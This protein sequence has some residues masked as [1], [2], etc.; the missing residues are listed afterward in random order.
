MYSF[1][2]RHSH[3]HRPYNAHPPE[4][5]PSYFGHSVHSNPDLIVSR[6][7]RLTPCALYPQIVQCDTDYGFFANSPPQLSVV[8][9]PL[10]AHHP[11]TSW[12][13]AYPV[14]PSRQTWRQ[15]HT[16]HLP[17]WRACLGVLPPSRYKSR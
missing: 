5:P 16:S 1:H 10:P 2:P 6:T 4:T 3:N 17:S 12:L 15:S 13:P 9:S 7:P 14:F 8:S 11:D